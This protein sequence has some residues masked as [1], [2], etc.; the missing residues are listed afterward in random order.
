MSDLVTIADEDKALEGGL[1][2]YREA[3]PTHLI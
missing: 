1:N 2:G 3:V